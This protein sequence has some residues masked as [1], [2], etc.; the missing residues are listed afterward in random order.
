MFMA[1]EKGMAGAGCWGA[2]NSE[3]GK[4]APLGLVRERLRPADAWCPRFH[5]KLSTGASCRNRLCRCWVR[6]QGLSTWNRQKLGPCEPWK[7]TGSNPRIVVPT[8]Q[9][10]PGLLM[11]NGFQAFDHRWR[12]R[13]KRASVTVLWI[14]VSVYERGSA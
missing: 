9:P 6:D 7:G 11:R 3:S 1:E 13:K 4:G 8:P 14:D 12:R 10:R 2:R 5:V